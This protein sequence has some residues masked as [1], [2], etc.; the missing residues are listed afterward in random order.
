MESPG[1]PEQAWRGALM[2]DDYAG[3]K[4]AVRPG[5]HRS[6]LPGGRAAQAPRVVAN[7][8]STLAEQALALF[9]KLREVQREVARLPTDERL[10]MRQLKAGPAA[11]ALQAWLLAQRQKV[12]AGSATAKAIDYSLGRWQALVAVNSTMAICRRTTTG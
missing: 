6:R 1:P 12:P 4:G 3:Q 5:Y 10:R 7:H 9:A 2:C 8:N 11:D